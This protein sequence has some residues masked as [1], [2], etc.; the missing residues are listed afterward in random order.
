VDIFTGCFLV[1]QLSLPELDEG[2]SFFSF[3]RSFIPAAFCRICTGTIWLAHQLNLLYLP[4]WFAS[5][6]TGFTH[7]AGALDG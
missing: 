2:D 7:T 1:F 5:T 3:D 4:L 6:I